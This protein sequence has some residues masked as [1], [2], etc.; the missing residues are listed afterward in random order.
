[1]RQHVHVKVRVRKF[2]SGRAQIQSPETKRLCSRKTK[3][4]SGDGGGGRTCKEGE[5]PCRASNALLSMYFTAGLFQLGSNIT[6]YILKL[7]TLMVQGKA[8]PSHI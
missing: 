8:E 5:L 6:S 3:K 2:L 7:I 1:M 4:A